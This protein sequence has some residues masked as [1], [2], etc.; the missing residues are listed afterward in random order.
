MMEML[1]RPFTTADYP[2]L[3]ALGNAA[4]SDAAGQPLLP[5]SAETLRATDEQRDPQCRFGRWV[6]E[7]AG[8]I[9]AVAEHDQTASRYHPRK[10]WL[11]LSVHPAYQGRGIGRRLYNYLLAAL[12]SYDPWLVRNTVREDQTRSIEFLTRRGWTEAQRTWESLLDLRAF[13]A[14]RYAGAQ[15][16]VQAQAMRI[17]TLPELAA[18]PE[19]DRKLYDLVWEIRQDFPELDPPTRESFETFC[20]QYLYHEAMLPDAYFVAVRGS[21]YVGYS[22]HTRLTDDS[23]IRIGQTGV[24]RSCRRQGIA[25]ALKLRGIGYAQARG[26]QTMRTVNAATNRGMLALNEQ[27]G[28]RKRPAWIDFVK[29]FGGDTGLVGLY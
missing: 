23:R 7:R 8:Q 2:A 4:Y 10:F 28:F 22:Y 17:V 24:R 6:A 1:I 26:Y 18:D 19:R 3:A 12:Q 14:A 9:V 29:T 11:D 20:A 16:R 21:E 15:E 25:L 5:I 13:D 27:L